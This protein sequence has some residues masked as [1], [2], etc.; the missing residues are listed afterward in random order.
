MNS[1]NTVRVLK[2]SLQEFEVG[3]HCVFIDKHWQLE[4]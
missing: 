3:T 1:H 4:S 2:M